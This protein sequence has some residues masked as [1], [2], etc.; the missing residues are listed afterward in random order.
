MPVQGNEALQCSNS[1]DREANAVQRSQCCCFVVI[2]SFLSF[3]VKTTV[4]LL[5]NITATCE[6]SVDGFGLHLTDSMVLC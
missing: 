1:V 3:A 6:R 5:I 4:D 2:V